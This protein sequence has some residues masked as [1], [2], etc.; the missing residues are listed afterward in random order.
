MAERHRVKGKVYVL[1][2]PVLSDY[3]DWRFEGPI[4]VAEAVDLLSEGFISAVGHMGAA[5][6]LSKRLGV[7]VTVQRFRAEMQPGDRALVLR[8]KCRL[9]EGAI[10]TAEEMEKLPVE[11]G[12]LTRLA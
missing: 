7:P 11:L 10:L 8:I 4:S 12:I 1:N 6:F 3:G 9:D 2:A 5:E